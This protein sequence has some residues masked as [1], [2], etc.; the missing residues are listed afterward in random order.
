MNGKMA[1]AA[2]L[3]KWHRQCFAEWMF[4]PVNEFTER[5][6]KVWICPASF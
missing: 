1:A 3:G 6:K 2:A 4:W 5:A